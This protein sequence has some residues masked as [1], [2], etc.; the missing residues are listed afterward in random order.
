M[1]RRRHG[2][3]ATDDGGRMVGTDLHALDVVT[4]FAQQDVENG[5]LDAAQHGITP[6]SPCQSRIEAGCVAAYYFF[7]ASLAP[8]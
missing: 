2:I 8:G 7:D 4:G 3:A 5:N 6:S 1:M